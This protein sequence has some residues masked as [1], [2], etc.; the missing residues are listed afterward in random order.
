M[1]YLFN[2]TDIKITLRKLIE[3]STY[4][5]VSNGMDASIRK[6]ALSADVDMKVVQ[7]QK[8]ASEMKL[9]AFGIDLAKALFQVH[10]VELDFS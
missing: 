10:G 6:T 5:N 8:G 4:N 7:D 1:L 9:S 2:K 3:R